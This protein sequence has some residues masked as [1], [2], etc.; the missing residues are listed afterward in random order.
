MFLSLLFREVKQ[1]YSKPTSCVN[2]YF[3][4]ITSQQNQLVKEIKRLNQRKYRKREKAFF[5]DG[6]QGVL[7]GVEAGAP[8]KAL[9]WCE[10]LLKSEK[11]LALVARHQGG[12]YAVSEDIYRSVSNRENPVGLAAIFEFESLGIDGLVAE[13]DG[14]YLALYEVG[15]PGNLG[16]ILRTA[17]A[18]GA[19]GVILIGNCVEV[20]HPSV[21]K[22][23]MGTIFS[24]PIIA[25]D[26]FDTLWGWTK[27]HRFQLVGTTAKTDLRFDA[28]DYENRTVLLMGSEKFGLDQDSLENCDF[29]V[30]IPMRG[31]SSSL[32]LG[33]SIGIIAYEIARNEEK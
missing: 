9:I 33:V 2:N 27:S 12:I 20:T 26:E 19:L 18:V 6:I 4:M 15:D 7:S 28:V 5:A 3:D 13:T 21:V 17:D 1:N 22:A 11:G 8:V 24:M 25:L 16:T 23:S 10:A 14:L 31:K 29:V 30:S 32:N